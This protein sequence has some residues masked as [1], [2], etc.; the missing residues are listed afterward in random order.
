MV[1]S[2][3]FG[4]AGRKLSSYFHPAA[5][6]CGMS[7]VAVNKI[8]SVPW[9]PL[10]VSACSIVCVATVCLAGGKQPSTCHKRRAL[11]QCG[12]ARAPPNTGAG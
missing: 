2:M 8:V 9:P 4:V 12:C 6:R 11:A 5:V 3:Y 10:R 1:G 7:P